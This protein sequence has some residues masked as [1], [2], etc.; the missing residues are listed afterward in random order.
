MRKIKARSVDV[1]MSVVKSKYPFARLITYKF[2]VD[3]RFS[4][5]KDFVNR[6][7]SVAF[8]RDFRVIR[9]RL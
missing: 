3:F 9:R 8:I 2:D 1:A 6:T 7:M 5:N 4:S